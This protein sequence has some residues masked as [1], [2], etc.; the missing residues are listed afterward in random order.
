[1]RKFKMPT[2]FTI[3]FAIILVMTILTWVVPSGSYEYTADGQ[4]IAGSYHRVD[5]QGQPITAVLTAPLEGLYEAIDIAA[6]ILMV[7]GFLGV[8]AK[9]GALDAGIANIIRK[10][11]G[12]EKLLIPILM[13]AFAL[14]GTTFGMAEETIAFYP[15]VLPIMVAAGYDA[16]TGVAVILL[17]AGAG[18]I[19]STVNPFATGIAAGFAGVSLGQGIGLRL[20]ILFIMLAL[21]I[22]FV[23]SYAQRVWNEPGKSLVADMRTENS[24]HFSAL[25]Q[26][27]I[28]MTGIHK[29]ALALFALTFLVMIYAVIPFQDMGLPL[30]ALGWWFPEL[31][32]LFLGASILLGL[33]CG[34][35]EG[36]IVNSFVSGAAELL[37]VAFIIGVSRGITVIMSRGQITDTILNLGERA[38]TG[39][40]S[41]GFLALTYL[42]FLPLS[43]LIPSTSGLAALSMPI[44]AP[45]A[46]FAGVGRALVITAFQSASGLVNLITPTSAVVMGALA[47]GRVPFDRWLRFTWKLLLLLFAVLLALLMAGTLLQ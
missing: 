12:R 33:C 17:G 47:L 35:A 21:S 10:L 40:G 42:L 30:P 38:L 43:F 44:M 46:D 37:S 41:A 2:A 34:L 18:V 19:G 7:G 29:L 24:A 23:M 31:S 27:E 36:E 15:L 28:H 32:A 45:L 8:V 25:R 13:G 4:P 16:L 22:W 1:M 20:V 26:E 39:A 11:K 9:T 3:L 14:G 6:F 5:N